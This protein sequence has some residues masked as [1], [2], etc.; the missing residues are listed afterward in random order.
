MLNENLIERSKVVSAEE[1]QR[2]FIDKGILKRI[3][4]ILMNRLQDDTENLGNATI[5]CYSLLFCIISLISQRVVQHGKKME[6]SNSKTNFLLQSSSKSVKLEH[7]SEKVIQVCRI[8][9]KLAP[10]SEN[11]KGNA[12]TI[13]DKAVKFG[14]RLLF[15]LAKASPDVVLALFKT[16]QDLSLWISITTLQTKSDFIRNEA[17]M[18]LLDICATN[19]GIVNLVWT[20]LIDIFGT[21]DFGHFRN[22][23]S[24]YFDLSCKLCYKIGSIDMDV[25]DLDSKFLSIF[26]QI[27]TFLQQPNICELSPTN[28]PDQLLIGL[29]K[30]ST[31]L[32]RVV[33]EKRNKQK[34]ENSQ[35]ESQPLLVD[36]ENKV[37]SFENSSKLECGAGK[38]G[39]LRELFEN[40]LFAIPVNGFL[41]GS[42]LPKCKTVDA[43]NAEEFAVDILMNRLQDDT[44]NLGNATIECYSRLNFH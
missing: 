30:L 17:K 41:S 27:Q 37:K 31:V 24:D 29:L 8:V 36:I 18:F 28:A 20:C 5:E 40:A 35:Q 6:H 25:D 38:R 19:S 16:K 32:L 43:R 3:L 33:T 12:K 14:L 13:H 44:E 10:H 4:D 42:A 39:F 1:L 23:C 7:L 22:S 11:G 34:K 26:C 15:E 2:E 9:A 21:P